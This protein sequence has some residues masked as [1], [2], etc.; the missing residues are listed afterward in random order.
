MAFF[1]HQA[2]HMKFK[3]NILKFIPVLLVEDNRLVN[4][5]LPYAV[6]CYQRSANPDESR[7]KLQ[8]FKMDHTYN[9][10]PL[11]KS[12]RQLAIEYRQLRREQLLAPLQLLILLTIIMSTHAHH[13]KCRQSHCVD[14]NSNILLTSDE[15]RTGPCPIV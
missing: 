6:A 5:E 2:I 13:T 15:L 7:F 1:I 8:G 12:P 3:R 4:F 10:L 9:S 14:R 11:I